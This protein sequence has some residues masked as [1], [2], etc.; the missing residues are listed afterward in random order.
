MAIYTLKQYKQ[1]KKAKVVKMTD[2]DLMIRN[3]IESVRV[4]LIT[5]DVF[6]RLYLQIESV[7]E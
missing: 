1:M 7:N 4:G 5:Y 3:L 2:K 6:L